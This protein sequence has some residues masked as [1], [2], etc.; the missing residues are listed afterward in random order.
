MAQTK[1]DTLATALVKFQ[2][3]LPRVAKSKTANV[4]TKNGGQY[5]YTYAD[6]A[7]VTDAAMPRLT[8]LGLS[9]TCRGRKTEDGRYELVGVL[10]HVSGETDEGA[11]PIAGNTPQEIG[12]AITYARRYLLGCMTGIVTEDDDDGAAASQGG[13]SQRSGGGARRG[14]QGSAPEPPE[15]PEQRLSNARAGA[16]TTFQQTEQDATQ[17]L[18]IESYEGWKAAPF[19]DATAED[20]D[21]FARVL[22]SQ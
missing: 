15:T 20:F 21:E 16:W 3:D 1:T 8:S 12:S 14:R 17:E 5:S 9:F 22:R 4:P 6:L 18:F 13:A 19:A 11:L 7:A 2:E 10:R